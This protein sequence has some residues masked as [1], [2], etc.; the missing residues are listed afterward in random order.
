MTNLFPKDIADRILSLGLHHR[1][2]V[3][4]W[5]VD[6]Y[7]EYI[8][9]LKTYSTDLERAWAPLR[10]KDNSIPGLYGVPLFTFNS[11]GA[12]EAELACRPKFC[13]TPGVWLELSNGEHLQL[14][15]EVKD[16]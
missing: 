1:R 6:R 11:Q 8:H 5:F 12:T 13:S 7:A 15:E 3:A 16:A 14:D 9:V 10:L 2:P 4:L